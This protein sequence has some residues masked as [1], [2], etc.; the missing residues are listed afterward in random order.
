MKLDNK[1]TKDL[2]SKEVWYRRNKT[3]FEWNKKNSLYKSIKLLRIISNIFRSGGIKACMLQ[4]PNYTQEQI[5]KMI[6]V[7]EKRDQYYKKHRK[8][9]Y[10]YNCK[11]SIN[12]YKIDPIFK[13]KCD[14]RTRN[15]MGLNG[16][17]KCD[18]T[19]KLLGCSFKELKVY[20]ESKFQPGMT[21]QNHSKTGW[22]IDHIKPLAAFN[23]VKESEQKIAF[24][25]TNLQPLWAKE[26]L[27]KSSWYDNKHYKI[28]K[29]G[30]PD[31][32][33]K[34]RYTPENMNLQG[35]IFGQKW[36]IDPR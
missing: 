32:G 29:H 4:Y 21:W 8:E 28:A 1:Q 11:Y 35:N 31:G 34:Y 26:N 14:I 16:I 15:R 5:I 6:G 17:L 12:R 7:L 13:L 3:S 20:L 24:H 2:V 27:I 30:Q 10:A 23:L 22:H 25:Y 19:Q 18:K 36:G 9:N 33:E